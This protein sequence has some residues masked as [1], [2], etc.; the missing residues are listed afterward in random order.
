MGIA[1]TYRP[2]L[3]PLGAKVHLLPW[4]GGG[5]V[6]RKLLLGGFSFIIQG[7]KGRVLTDRMLEG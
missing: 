6:E 2:Q 5:E 4:R 7:A 3:R 1:P